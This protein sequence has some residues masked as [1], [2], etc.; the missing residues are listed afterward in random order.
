MQTTEQ[1]ILPELFNLADLSIRSL[2]DKI[3]IGQIAK[4]SLESSI[5]DK[6]DLLTCDKRDLD[7]RIESAKTKLFFFTDTDSVVINGNIILIKSLKNKE[8][9]GIALRALLCPECSNLEHSIRHQ[10]DKL[11]ELDLR[12]NNIRRELRVLNLELQYRLKPE[13][14]SINYNGF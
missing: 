5:L 1:K 4:S 9:R 2:I 14:G 7:S 6:R 3:Q 12:L 13:A 10:N 11:N 8:Q